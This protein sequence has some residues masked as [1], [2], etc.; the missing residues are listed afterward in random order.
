MDGSWETYVDV[1]IQRYSLQLVDRDEFVRLV[2][3][4]MGT[5][6]NTSGTAGVRAAVLCVYSVALYR[7]CSGAEGQPRQEQAYDELA[8]FLTQIA[9]RRYGTV[10]ADAT[11]GALERIYRSL[12]HCRQ[13][14]TFLAFALQKLRDAARIELQSL[15]QADANLSLDAENMYGTSHIAATDADLADTALRHDMRRRL[16]ACTEHFMH[17]HPRAACQLAALWMKYIDGLDDRTIA[18][19]LG[20]TVSA[21]SSPALA[22]SRAPA[23]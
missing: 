12:A 16:V 11:Q 7:A 18:Q 23:L 19:R 4:K 5:C 6:T 21:C 10:C 13:P 15:H 17:E 14:E 3:H 9:S 20:K 8:T 1:Y 2:Q 22:R